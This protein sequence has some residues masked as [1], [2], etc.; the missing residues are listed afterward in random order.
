VL[1][2][3]GLDGTP[4]QLANP[5]RGVEV[6]LAGFPGNEAL[7]TVPGRLGDTGEIVLANAYGI[8]RTFRTVTTIRANVRAGNSG[9]PA[10]DAAGRV[11]TTVFARRADD[12]GGY[13]IPTAV[14][15][16]AV[17]NAGDKALRRTPCVGP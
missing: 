16:G 4:L 10:I 6:A 14:V 9:S 17:Q 1:R 2:V 5:A 13:G 7:S 12:A 15:R 8:R 3:A 11:R